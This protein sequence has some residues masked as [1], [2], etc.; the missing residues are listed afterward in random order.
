M[1]LIGAG[2]AEWGNMV[3]DSSV[4]IGNCSV[5]S[6]VV[7][8]GANAYRVTSLANAATN[9]FRI[10]RMRGEGHQAFSLQEPRVSFWFRA[11]TLPASGIETMGGFTRAG[12]GF[13]VDLRISS[14]GIL[15]VVGLRNSPATQTGTTALSTATWYHINF[16]WNASTGNA[17]VEINGVGEISGNVGT[18]QFAGFAV[19]GK[20]GNVSTQA[21]DFYY[22]DIIVDDATFNTGAVLAF[23]QPSAN[24]TYT[25]WPNGTGAS[26]Y[27]EIDETPN[28]SATYVMSGAIATNDYATFPFASISSV[29]G[30]GTVVGV[31]L[32]GW[33]RGDVATGQ[34]NLVTYQGATLYPALFTPTPSTT[35]SF[36]GHSRAVDPNTGVTWT[37]SGLDAAEFGFLKP[38]SSS[39]AVRCESFGLYVAYIPSASTNYLLAAG[40]GAFTLTG[41][42]TT[43]AFNRILQAETGVFTFTGNASTLTYTP[44]EN[45]NYL[46]AAGAGSFTLTGNPVTLTKTYILNAETGSFALTGPSVTLHHGYTFSLAPG[47]YTLTGNPV[48]FS[49]NRVLPAEVGV[50]TVTGNSVEFNY[51]GAPEEPTPYTLP[52]DPLALLPANVFPTPSRIAAIVNFVE[53]NYRLPTAEEV[54]LLTRQPVNHGTT[55]A[56]LPDGYDG[57][58]WNNP[59]WLRDL[60]RRNS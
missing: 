41:N 12:G 1:A 53:T 25:D 32:Q 17:T 49:R 7:H 8:S 30:T 6:T 10:G 13:Q 11:D 31:S 29:I 26:G 28:D 42:P 57:R 4:F 2:G 37:P 24:G 60:T 38:S 23:F 48:T 34:V 14:S 33:F 56:P 47:T 20:R 46:L 16:S 27:T 55:T 15:S 43:L 18:D 39:N 5:Q 21:V 40:T 51:S 22:D 9:F 59:N 44:S 54:I 45:V 19:F 50:F 36:Y 52:Y 3:A 35:P 58:D